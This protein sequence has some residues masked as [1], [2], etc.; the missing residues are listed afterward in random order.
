MSPSLLIRFRLYW[1]L[2]LRPDCTDC[3]I[4]IVAQD[5]LH[6]NPD[7]RF[8]LRTTRAQSASL[9]MLVHNGEFERASLASFTS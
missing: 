2:P 9:R 4:Q 7:I 6:N 3:A 5:T 8:A 1:H